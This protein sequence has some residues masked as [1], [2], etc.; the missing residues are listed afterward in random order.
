MDKLLVDD[1]LLCLQTT[2][3]RAMW[4]AKLASWVLCCDAKTTAL[5]LALQGFIILCN[6][7]VDTLCSAQ[8][9][10]FIRVEACHLT[11]WNGS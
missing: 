5:K 1:P 2:Q 4:T 10:F 11:S 8:K 9:I 3:G 7:I 6:T